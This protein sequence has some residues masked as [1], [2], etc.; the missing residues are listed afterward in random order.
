M[1][2]G[3]AL[4]EAERAREEAEPRAISM[5]PLQAF[6]CSPSQSIAA[7]APPL[8]CGMPSAASAISIDAQ[9]AQDHR[10]VDVAHV[11]DAERLAGELA[12]A[13]AQHHAA[14]LVAVGAQRLGIVAVASARG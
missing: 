8:P 2:R 10:R 3:L 12:D 1:R 13:L 4:E 7:C 6:T 14:F 11:G 9:R 5:D